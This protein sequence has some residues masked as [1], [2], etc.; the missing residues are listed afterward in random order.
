MIPVPVKPVDIIVTVL[1]PV[2]GGVTVYYLK[3]VALLSPSLVAHHLADGLWAFSFVNAMLIVWDRQL[4]RVWFTLVFFV[5]A[6][7]ELLQY[8]NVIAGTGDV[9]DTLTYFLFGVLG[10]VTNNYFIKLFHP[11][12]KQHEVG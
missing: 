2:I 12:N 9:Y 10:I 7:Y 5:F 1:L 11:I 4:H 3:N 8:Q 6:I